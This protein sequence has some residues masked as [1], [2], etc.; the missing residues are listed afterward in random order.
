MFPAMERRRLRS[1]EAGEFSAFF[2]SL[3]ANSVE[4]AFSFTHGS[5]TAPPHEARALSMSRRA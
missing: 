3:F 5:G 2:M 4:S 1:K